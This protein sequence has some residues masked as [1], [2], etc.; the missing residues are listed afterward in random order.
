[1]RCPRLALLALV[2]LLASPALA[3]AEDDPPPHPQALRLLEA[4][5]RYRS[6]EGR[7]ALPPIPGGPALRLGDRGPRV[8]ALRTHLAEDARGDG[9][10]LPPPVA[11]ADLLDPTLAE[12]VRA[13]QERHGLEPDGVAGSK[14][15]G[16]LSR[17]PADHLRQILLNLER[18]R[19]MPRDLGERYVL[20]NIAGFHLEAFASGRRELDL[21]VIVGRPATRTPLFSSVLQGVTLNPSWSVPGSI[22]RNEI[23]P[24]AARDPSYLGRNGYQVLPDGR[25]RQKPGAG[26]SL[27]RLKFV[28]PNRFGV[29]LHDTPSHGLFDRTVRTFSHGCIRVEDP[30]G[31]AVWVLDDPAWTR[32]TLAAA[33]ATGRERT[34]P[35]ADAVQIHVGYWTAWVDDT[36][37]LQVGRDV[38]GRDAEPG[39]PS[40]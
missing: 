1:M 17:G 25:L 7:P 10:P 32:E 18:W 3:A 28:F 2:S 35:V 20:V 12:A 14:T 26:N 11:P 31:L 21:R 27:G 6:V 33:I 4:L 8:A 34:L 9:A 16:E 29:Y 40:R 15:L 19:W 36:G 30:A 37:T 22:A 24:K 5:A 39:G 13:F 38:Y 23:W